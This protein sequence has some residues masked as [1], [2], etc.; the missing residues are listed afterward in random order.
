MTVVH[1]LPAKKPVP[2]ALVQA[3]FADT[4]RGAK[5]VLVR[6]KVIHG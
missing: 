1:F 2:P 6:S 5:V 4:A 3:I